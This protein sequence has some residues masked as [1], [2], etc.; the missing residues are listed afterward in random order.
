MQQYAGS[1]S[2]Y[3]K[4]SD[5]GGKRPTVIIEAVG[6]VEFDDDDKGKHVRPA[7]KFKDKDKQLVLNPTNT[8]EIIRAFGR[9][10]EDWIGKSIS[11]STK[12]YKAFDREGIV[13]TAVAEDDPSDD[14]PW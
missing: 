9:E 1:E 2:K 11:L 7:L 13:V 8:E 3:L 10:S 4:A 5:L 12:F 14:I 6:K